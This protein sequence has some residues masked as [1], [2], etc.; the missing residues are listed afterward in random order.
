LP[1]CL[2]SHRVEPRRAA[3]RPRFCRRSGTPDVLLRGRV[4]GRTCRFF[5]PKAFFCTTSTRNARSCGR[6]ESMSR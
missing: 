4:P 1:S 5:T 2:A 6:V 3:C